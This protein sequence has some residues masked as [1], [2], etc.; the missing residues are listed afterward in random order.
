MSLFE[1]F[2]AEPRRKLLEIAEPSY[3]AASQDQQSM[4]KLDKVQF[5][6]PEQLRCVAVANSMLAVALRTVMGPKETVKL[7]L[8]RIA[9]EKSDAVQD[10]L[11]QS[12]QKSDSIQR[13]FYSPKANHLLISCVSG[14][15]YYLHA[16]WNKP[17]LLSK[18]KFCVT[19]AS[20]SHTETSVSSGPLL[21]CSSQGLVV[22]LAVGPSDELFQKEERYCTQLLTLNAPITGIHAEKLDNP[23]MRNSFLVA[24]ATKAR[25]YQ[26]AGPVGNDPASAVYSS[27]FANGPTDCQELGEMKA[28]ELRVLRHTSD[29]GS[30]LSIGWSTP[31]GIYTGRLNLFGSTTS[32]SYI[33]D[34]QI[35]PYP[36]TGDDDV[37]RNIVS[38]L[39]TEFHFLVLF[40][41][42]L[43]ALSALDNKVVAREKF[44]LDT[45]ESVV[46]LT[47]DPLAGTLWA[48]TNLNLYEII[49]FDEGRDVWK[50]YLDRNAFEKAFSSAQTDE[51]R[52]IVKRR[53]ADYDFAHK[54]YSLAA[55]HYA[56]TDVS[57]EETCLRFL[58]L[59][60]ESALMV[61]LR[62]KLAVLKRSDVTQV[63]LI[64]TW[65]TELMA[66][67]ICALEQ[68]LNTLS[69]RL[70][71]NPQSKT[72]EGEAEVIAAKKQSEALSKDLM[73]LL[74]EYK[75][76]LHQ[77]T[78][79][80][81]LGSYGRSLELTKFAE[82]SNDWEKLISSY[83]ER[84][85]WAKALDVISRQDSVDLYYKHSS[86]LI[87]HIPTQVISLWMKVPSLNPRFLMPSM[88]NIHYMQ[89]NAGPTQ[90]LITYLEYLV[91]LGNRDRVVHNYLFLLFAMKSTTTDES[92]ILSFI[93]SQR[94][95]LLFDLPYAL[96][97]C[98]QYAL[99]QSRV[100][101]FALTGLFD[102]AI[103]LALD[104]NDLELAKIIAEKPE[105]DAE[106]RKRLWIRIAE[107][108]INHSTDV[109]TSLQYLKSGDLKIEEILPF[110]PDFV[111][112]D[113]F[114]EE[115]CDAL[116]EY[117]VYIDGLKTDLDEATKASESIR[118]DIR[119]LKNRYVVVPV[120]EACQ[121]CYRALMTRQFFSFP[122]H[123][124]FHAD[125][126]MDLVVR[127]T[128]RGKKVLQIKKQLEKNDV[129]NPVRS[130]SPNGKIQLKVNQ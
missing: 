32:D 128:V 35:L 37:S 17:K 15:N 51:Q 93:N 104:R 68:R 8:L 117:N 120:T 4:F 56:A 77:P 98:G 18:L 27:V 62:K 63:T 70:K 48:H 7:R 33:E 59:E 31:P 34:A 122:C 19:A 6:F 102:E 3:S 127:E 45:G 89:S 109:K 79:Y 110:F 78:I 23:L 65:L 96:R 126:L 90:S 124:S 28:S 52:S 29:K 118:Q 5:S 82:L 24:I 107:H 40:P 91:Q 38:F 83:M 69:I 43:V 14:D 49:A 67:K 108:V 99:T 60:Q 30:S 47:L 26:F 111:L 44:D 103:H 112:I 13:L 116:E 84:H 114:K 50:I 88:L 58:G 97:I 123:H 46:G 36:L 94:Q 66:G 125:C 76:K 20:W 115:L 11:F 12:K 119:D 64:A 57:F 55:E 105:D 22:E 41:T 25:L 101:L 61:Y 106:L 10:I 100:Q 53:Q 85:E 71:N 73:A 39:L 54:R 72:D 95:D 16:K 2:E 80:S 74:S 21:V 1:H 9:L 87:Q 130:V 129:A 121:I 75:D 81:L 92:P 86:T 113:D 42:E